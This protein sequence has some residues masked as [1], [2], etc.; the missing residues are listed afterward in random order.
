MK[1]IVVTGMAAAAALVM[2][3]AVPGT[4]NAASNTT[5]GSGPVL[6]YAYSNGNYTGAVLTIRGDCGASGAGSQLFNLPHEWNDTISS[7]KPATKF[8][9]F[10][11]YE[12]GNGVGSEYYIPAAN[13]G[14]TGLEVVLHFNDMTSSI[15]CWF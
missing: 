8:Y 9:D 15:R 1:R 6:G 10:S 13:S 3:L 2:T 11:L 14:D 7:F 4:A 5:I 12:H